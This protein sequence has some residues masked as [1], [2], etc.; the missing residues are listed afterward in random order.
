MI[1][2]DVLDLLVG[3]LIEIIKDEY[4]RG[5]RRRSL[6]GRR[7]SDSGSRRPRGSGTIEVL[8]PQLGP[9][10]NNS[11]RMSG[12]RDLAKRLQDTLGIGRRIA[13]HKNEGPVAAAQSDK[14]ATGYA[15]V[16]RRARNVIRRS[17]DL[18]ESGGG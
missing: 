12:P 16:M 10:R 2:N 15:L 9:A 11:R 14:D 8:A 17:P 3:K 4:W 18:E 6:I 5:M 7:S 1:F 13:C